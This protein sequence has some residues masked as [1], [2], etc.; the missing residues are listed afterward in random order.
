VEAVIPSRK[1]RRSEFMSA[2]RRE[3]RVGPF[4]LLFLAGFIV[5]GFAFGRML[6]C[7]SVFAVTEVALILF[8]LPLA[9]WR[10]SPEVTEERKVVFNDDGMM[11]IGTTSAIQVLWPA[12]SRTTERDRYYVLKRTERRAPTIVMKRFLAKPEEVKFRA[13]VRTHTR[14][15]LRDSTDEKLRD[16]SH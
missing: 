4:D 5:Y 9:L 12:Y 1:W 6:W 2:H 7:L 16:S 13:L 14:A 3:Y 10:K 11:I 8:L 15:T